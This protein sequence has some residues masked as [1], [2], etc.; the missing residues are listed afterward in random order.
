M[1]WV[2]VR[3]GDDWTEG[4]RRA[5]RRTRSLVRIVGGSRRRNSVWRRR[6]VDVDSCTQSRRIRRGGTGRLSV[7]SRRMIQFVDRYGMVSSSRG[8]RIADC[9]IITLAGVI[10]IASLICTARDAVDSPL[11]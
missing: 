1:F 9:V 6:D 11:P 5:R 7:A 8:S 10:V 3:R 4:R 2:K